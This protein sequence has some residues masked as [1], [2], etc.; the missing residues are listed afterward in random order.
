MINMT[1]Y[2]K[3][4]YKFI[5][6]ILVAA[7]IVFSFLTLQDIGNVDMSLT[8]A[9]RVH[10]LQFLQE[11]LPEYFKNIQWLCSLTVYDWIRNRM[12]TC[13]FSFEIYWPQNGIFEVFSKSVIENGHLVDKSQ[14]IINASDGN[15][16]EKY[17]F[18]LYNVNRVNINCHAY[19]LDFYRLSNTQL[20]GQKKVVCTRSDVNKETWKASKTLITITL[21]FS[22]E[23]IPLNGTL[24]IERS[25]STLLSISYI[26]NI[27]TI[28]YGSFKHFI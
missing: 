2:N 28:R 5:D 11:Q 8:N 12:I 16:N 26:L 10:F 3:N 22:S 23:L 18:N 24:S 9:D 7:K 27:I 21:S 13:N 15:L 6:K 1:S 25:T 20:M 14:L 19:D 17:A 4:G